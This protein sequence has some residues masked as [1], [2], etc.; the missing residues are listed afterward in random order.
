MPAKKNG[1]NVTPTTKRARVFA[2][3]RFMVA[4]EW[5]DGVEKSAELAREWKLSAS[6]IRGMS[7]EA[8]RLLDFHTMQ[9]NDL[10]R[11]GQLRLREIGEENGPDRV[12]AWRTL[13]ENLGEL[14]KR[15]EVSGPGGVPTAIALSG[16]ITATVKMEP[17]EHLRALL[18]DPPPELEA[19]LVEEWGPRTRGE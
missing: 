8:S 17:L 5:G 18:R 3:A 19:I 2:I 16:G 6:S 9:R 15:V 4:G 10:V 1:E 13:F 11:L 7:A 14:R 12:V